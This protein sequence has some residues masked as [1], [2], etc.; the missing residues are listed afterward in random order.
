MLNICMCG[1]QAGYPHDPSCP[2]PL[3]RASDEDAEKWAREYTALKFPQ[4]A[5]VVRIVDIDTR[6]AEAAAQIAAL[7]AAARA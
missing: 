2:Y 7:D 1:T 5:P 4:P 3:F 6:L